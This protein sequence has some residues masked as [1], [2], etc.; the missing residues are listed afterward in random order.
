MIEV[1]E[2]FPENVVA[3]AGK[4]RVTRNDYDAVLIPEVK[5]A[6]SRRKKIRCYYELGPE[7]SGM[8][9]GAAW[10]DFK[11][12]IE[13]LTRWERVAVVTDVNWIRLSMNVFRF[14]MPGEIRIFGTNEASEARHWV[15][16][17]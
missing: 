8:D 12:G 7:F 1:L 2:D 14:L 6:L 4:G 5:R 13:H 3:F 11:V 9:S 17:D 10:E 15:A 16:A